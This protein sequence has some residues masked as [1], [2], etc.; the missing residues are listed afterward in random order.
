MLFRSDAIKFYN[1]YGVKRE[2]DSIPTMHHTVVDITPAGIHTV[3]D[4]EVQKTHSFLAN[5]VV[6]HNCMI[7]HGT[8]K[9]LQERLFEQSDNYSVTICEKCGN[10]ATNENE[11]Q[12]CETDNVVDIKLPYVSKLVLQ[13]LNAMLIK[14]KIKAKE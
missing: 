2:Q 7:G 14:T 9:F 5:G 4:I 1:G 10:F 6:A 8:S 13:E 11:C 3:Y 12:A